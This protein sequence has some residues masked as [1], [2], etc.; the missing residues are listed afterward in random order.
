MKL[1]VVTVAAVALLGAA[2]PP[3]LSFGGWSMQ[4]S[5][6]VTN[7]M[8]GDFTLPAHVSMQR[9]DGSTVDADRASGNFKRRTIDLN[10][11][12]VLH[13]NGGA[14][15]KR[16]GVN[17]GKKPKPA[18]MDC[19]RLQIDEIANL[20][21]AT[22]AVKYKQGTSVMNADKVVLDNGKHKVHLS[23]HVKVSQ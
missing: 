21:V 23:G 13:D 16:V 9:S 8:T 7:V 11:H 15:G 19:N 18:T 5:D 22:G 1:L 6:V 17:A 14:L 3:A 4:T 12:V 20:Y 10:G 2:K